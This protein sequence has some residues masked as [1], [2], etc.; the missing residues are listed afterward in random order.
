MG[1]GAVVHTL[2]P[3]LFPADLEYIIN[4]AQDKVLLLDLTFVELIQKLRPKLPSV[5]AYI[6]MTD[7][8]HMPR[9]P[10]KVMFLREFSITHR[11]Q[12]SLHSSVGLFVHSIHHIAF[13]VA[14]SLTSQ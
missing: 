4:H 9:Q 10:P 6:I 7:A 8:A 11:H 3:R 12:I 13:C 1:V 14:L 2:N 5:K